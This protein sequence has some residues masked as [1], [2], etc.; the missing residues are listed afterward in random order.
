M[1]DKRNR[2]TYVLSERKR[3]DL[4]KIKKMGEGIWDEL[5]VKKNRMDVLKG[6]G[7]VSDVVHNETM[8]YLG[9]L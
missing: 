8:R 9:E 4:L 1:W 6:Y 3:F 5:E 2:D 7:E